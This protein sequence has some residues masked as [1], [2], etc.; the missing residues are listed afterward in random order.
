[1]K[2]SKNQLPVEL[3]HILATIGVA[4]GDVSA[5]ER[6]V[7]ERAAAQVQDYIEVMFHKISQFHGVEISSDVHETMHM[8]QQ[9][10][11]L[12]SAEKLVISDGSHPT[13]I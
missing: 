13:C 8:L 11:R 10:T 2:K 7:K 4:D 1:M 3:K 12:R 5:V 6:R 9:H